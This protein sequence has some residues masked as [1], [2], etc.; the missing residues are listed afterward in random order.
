MTNEVH[1][2]GLK[3]KT[4]HQDQQFGPFEGHQNWLDQHWQEKLP[5]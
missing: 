1:G 2:L 4:N 3:A 5:E